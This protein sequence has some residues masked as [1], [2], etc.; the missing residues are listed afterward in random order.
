M[1]CFRKLVFLSSIVLI[2]VSTFGQEAAAVDTIKAS[3]AKATTAAEKVSVLDNLSRT[4]MN[5]N[6]Q[7][8]DKYGQQMV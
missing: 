2:G 1:S 7:E 6:I 4:L 3:L 5:V 8:A